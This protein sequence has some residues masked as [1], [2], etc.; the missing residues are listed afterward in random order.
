MI[1]IAAFVDDA[2]LRANNEPK[3]RK[4]S[5]IALCRRTRPHQDDA[6]ASRRRRIAK[7]RP[8]ARAYDDRAGDSPEDVKKGRAGPRDDRVL[9]LQFYDAIEPRAAGR[10]DE[11]VTR[12]GVP[13][14]PGLVA[15]SGS[16]RRDDERPA[17]RCKRRGYRCAVR[18]RPIRTSTVR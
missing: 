14:S 5:E 2:G 3:G 7:H 12:P 10:C 1:F 8:E 16:I 13:R 6:A 4:R 9:R 15:S 11:E 18:G 17:P